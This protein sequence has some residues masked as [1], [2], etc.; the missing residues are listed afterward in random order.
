M[1]SLQLPMQEALKQVWDATLFLLRVIVQ[2]VTSF[3]LMVQEFLPYIH[4]CTFPPQPLSCL[5][6]SH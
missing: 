3:S 4:A 5:L 2:V 1:I 6:Q